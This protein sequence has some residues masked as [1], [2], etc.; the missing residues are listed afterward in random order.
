MMGG[1]TKDKLIQFLNSLSK[2]MENDLKVTQE[3]RKLYEQCVNNEFLGAFFFL[4][5]LALVSLAVFFYALEY[6]S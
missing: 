4:I 5:N 6:I 3:P 1:V 2:L